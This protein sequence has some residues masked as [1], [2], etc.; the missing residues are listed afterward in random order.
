MKLTKL[1]PHQQI[2]GLS[3][4]SVQDFWIWAYADLLTG[5]VRNAFAEF[6]VGFALGSLA[7]P[8]AWIQRRGLPYRGCR[9]DVRAAAYVQSEPQERPSRIRYD[10]GSGPAPDE[11]DPSVDVFVFCLFAWDDYIDKDA[12]RNAMIDSANWVFFVVPAAAVTAARADQKMVGLRWLHQH[13][14]GGPVPFAF[15]QDRI[16]FTLG[17]D[18]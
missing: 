8:R 11:A 1:H 3:G 12:A 5:S 18:N 13:A 14:T 4:L 16:D 2:T 6:M 15:L 7:Q 9:I 10:I 17:V